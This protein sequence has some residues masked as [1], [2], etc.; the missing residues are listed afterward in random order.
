M[1]MPPSEEKTNKIKVVSLGGCVSDQIAQSM[2]DTYYVNCGHFWRRPTIPLVSAPVEYYN[3]KTSL[4]PKEYVGYFINDVNKL[5]FKDFMSIN[6]ETVVIMDIT[7]DYL[8]G[9]VEL[10]EDKYA[11]NPIDGK[12][13]LF[14]LNNETINEEILKE[15]LR[16]DKLVTHNAAKQPD[17]FFE[18]W[19]KSIVKLS[20]IFSEKFPHV[21]VPEVYF[22]TESLELHEGHQLDTNSPPVANP[23]LAKMYN[24]IR[25]HTKFKVISAP[26]HRML[27]GSDVPWGG[28]TVTHF[29][30]ETYAIFCQEADKIIRGLDHVDTFYLERAAFNRAALHA[31]EQRAKLIAEKRIAALNVDIESLK[32][33]ATSLEK[34]LS[35]MNASLNTEIEDHGATK[36]E[37]QELKT[38]LVETQANLIESLQTHNS[39]Q[40]RLVHSEHLNAQIGERVTELKAELKRPLY[41]HARKSVARSTRLLRKGRG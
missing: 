1:Y 28:P 2:D 15:I 34:M 26:R 21:L 40:L 29:I 19:S 7:R 31:K 16:K 37:L 23:I 39:I 10:E 17:S 22:C 20:D 8:T 30:T 12:G 5:H 33:A 32:D 35:D 25:N 11:L 13:F 9:V 18:L 41:Y 6:S 24:F 38:T 3:Y 36:L 14:G 4:M 27:T